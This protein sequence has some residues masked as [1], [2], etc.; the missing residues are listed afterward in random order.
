MDNEKHLNFAGSL[1]IFFILLFVYSK[2]GPSLPISILTQTKG[3]PLIV[4]ETG[5]VTAIP[6]IAKVSLGI[7]E[8]GVSLKVVQD[9][10]NSKSKKLTNELKKLGIDEKDIKTVNY[11]VY[12]E[13]SYDITPFK[14]SGYRVS[15]TYEV[16][17]DNFEKIND[18]LV[19][20]TQAGANVAGNISFEIN[21][22][23]K[24]ELTQKA[25][26]EAVKKAKDKA[27][28]LASSAGISLGKIINISESTG[29]DYPRPIAMMDKGLGGGEPI[30]ANIKPGETEI[31]KGLYRN[32]IIYS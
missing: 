30:T 7:E 21:E 26:E 3:E 10:V 15:T 13:Y 25:R 16:K 27:K 18:V 4:S 14:I 19:V 1:L 9:S 12:P 22:K 8:Q 31:N 6:D 17:I 23:T 11:N 29:I 28:G 5:K 24:E 20:S 32:K 2:W